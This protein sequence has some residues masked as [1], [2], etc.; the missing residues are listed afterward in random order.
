MVR[1]WPVV[2]LEAVATTQLGKALTPS[3]REGPRQRPYIRNANVQWDRIDMSDVAT[4]HFTPEESEKYALESGDVLVCEGGEIGRCAVW[5]RASGTHH[6]QK[7]IH[8]VRPRKSAPHT[9]EPRWLYYC[10][11]WLAESGALARVARG[12]TILHLTQPALRSLP[13]PIPERTVQLE[14]INRLDRA[15]ELGD[16][17]AA[18][19]ENAETL[20]GA[21]RLAILDSAVHPVVPPPA[22][23]KEP[24]LPDG[25]TRVR[26]G[27][28]AETIDGGSSAAPSDDADGT[29]ILRSSS[30]R[31]MHLAR[32][33]VRFVPFGK[34]VR[35]KD[36]VRNGDLLVTRLSGTLDY[37]GNAAVVRE[38]E[39]RSLLFPDRLFRCRFKDAQLADYLELF[40]A[41]SVY[42]QQVQAASRSAAGH[43]R[44]ALSDLRRFL[45]TLPPQAERDAIVGHAREQLAAV[46]AAEQRLETARAHLTE[47]ARRIL[48]VTFSGVEQASDPSGAEAGRPEHEDVLRPRLRPL[49][50]IEQELVLSNASEDAHAAEKRIVAALVDAN[51]PLTPE[52]LFRAAGYKVRSDLQAVESFYDE[53]RA[54][55]ASGRVLEM[56]GARGSDQVQ[57]AARPET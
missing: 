12:S 2:P 52:Q 27:E 4:M 48:E 3:A 35:P 36:F 5:S 33:D 39:E 45:V 25:W 31:S 29:P 23:S 54:A 49:S 18:R 16:L 44:I 53:L 57:L 22:T 7:A 17:A 9:L 19:M 15:F 13:L 21:A 56:R 8:R 46:A 28:L 42:R 11:R 24:T 38:V 20:L 30:V 1:T 51:V 14:L 50:T 34:P 47:T 10:L 55:Q 32:D 40:M 26:L 6:F 43:Q 41:S 37:V